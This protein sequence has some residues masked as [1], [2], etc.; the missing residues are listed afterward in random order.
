MD[1]TAGRVAKSN[2]EITQQIARNHTG[3]FI[4]AM[5]RADIAIASSGS[6]TKGFLARAAIAA[7]VNTEA[8]N[9][10]DVRAS[11]SWRCT[12]V[13]PMVFTAISGALPMVPANTAS[14]SV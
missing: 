1:G 4:H 2:I 3:E 14:S 11:G 5:T 10:T 12:S 6:S 8:N 13:A 7:P 9:P